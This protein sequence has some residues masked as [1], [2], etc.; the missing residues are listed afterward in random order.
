VRDLLND[1][2]Y[3]WQGEWNYVELRPHEIPAHIF[4]VEPIFER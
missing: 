2:E 3:V 4:R 1:A